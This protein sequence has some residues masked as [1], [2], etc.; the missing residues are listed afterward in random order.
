MPVFHRR[1]G[2][3]AFVLAVCTPVVLGSTGAATDAPTRGEHPEV[4]PGGAATYTGRLDRNAFSHPAP[5]MPLERRMAFEL[6]RS[7]FERLWVTAPSSTQAAD[8]LGP[9]YNARSCR[10]CHPRNGRGQ[11][12]EGSGEESVSL[13]L[14][15]DVPPRNDRER[16]SLGE[17]KVANLPDPVYGLQLQR[18][19]I[20]GHAA[21]YRLAVSYEE[22][23]VALACGESAGLRWP[24][25]TVTDLGY[26]PLHPL[27]RLSPRVAPQ[28]IGLG[29]LE[30]VDEQDI[31]VLADP[32]DRNGD[33]I[34]GRPNRVWNKRQGR[35][36]TGR[37]GHKAGMPS[38]DEQ[39]QAAFVQ[40]IGISVPLHPDGA[41]DCKPGQRSCRHA[42]DGNSP[43]YDHLEAPGQVT[44][45][46]ALYARNL[47]VP[48][49]RDRDDPDV[50]AGQRLF[51]DIGCSQCHTPIFVTREDAVDPEASGQTI[52]PYTDLLL[53]D[54]GEGLADHRPEGDADGREWR[55]APLW[56]VGLTAM[57][58]G[59]SYLLHD[60]R[61][62]NVLEA[63][64]W[65]GGEAGRHRDAV[66]RLSKAERNQLI[67]FVE[68]L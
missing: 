10:S 12:P 14:R 54:L 5:G 22:I 44:D 25:Y 11:P 20:S 37:F 31:L 55:T 19:A 49:R 4:E 38:V 43:Q 16:Q 1:L 39:S 9:L 60:G 13:L 42:P 47:A 15:V 2:N 17:H 40:N 34:S 3:A 36:V 57:V 58:S 48:A 63:V 30:A 33:S 29:L 64:L 53:H 41:G 51:E 45:L 65:H 35:V 7:L 32:E 67:R 50:L 46:I 28:M 24:T 6:G 18:A 61:A 23:P 27:A 68:S 59:H 56:G 21:E 8:G 66:T 52:G 62:R 26:G